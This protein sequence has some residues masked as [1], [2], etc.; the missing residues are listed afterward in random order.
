M[1]IDGVE[2]GIVLDHIR[3]GDCMKLYYLL[4]LDEL[5]CSVAIIKNAYSQKMGRKDIIKI[6]AP[7]D[8]DL[9]ALGYIDSRITVNLVRDGKLFQK[10]H[11]S[12]PQELVNIVVC[13]N[14]RCITSTENDVDQV[15]RLSDPERQLYRCVYCETAPES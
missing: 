8:L 11:L 15:F 9:D 1:N 4:G 3:A 12:L 13:K 7:L 10:K 2:N 14:P 6:D 5:D